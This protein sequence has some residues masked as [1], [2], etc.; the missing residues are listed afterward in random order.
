MLPT[1]VNSGI[2]DPGMYPAAQ[3]TL[4]EPYVPLLEITAR[5]VPAAMSMK[6]TFV[7][8]TWHLT[9]II[10]SVHKAQITAEVK[11]NRYTISQVGAVQMSQGQPERQRGRTCRVLSAQGEL[12]AVLCPPIN[13]LISH[14]NFAA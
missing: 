8:L 12:G 7:C 1:V 4:R 3:E 10:K 5:L 6:D 11:L 2:S 9:L 13:Y 14:G